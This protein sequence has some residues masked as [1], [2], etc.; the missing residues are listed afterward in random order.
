[1]NMFIAPIMFIA[2]FAVSLAHFL[3]SIGR[4]WP[5]RNEKLLA[6]TVVGFKDI[7]RMPPRLASLGISIATIAA[8][9]CALALADHESGGIPLD[10]G[11]VALA[12]VFLARGIAGYTTWWKTLTPE[13]NFRLNDARVY[14]PLCLALGL[15]FLTLVVFR[16]L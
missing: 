11:G 6:Q 8:G 9:V 12:A 2:L 10:L 4:T 15:G 5:I 14:S 7:E 1:M 13:P 3:W 16:Y